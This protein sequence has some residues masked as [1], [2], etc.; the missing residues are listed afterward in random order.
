MMICMEDC[1]SGEKTGIFRFYKGENQEKT[2][3]FHEIQNNI[4]NWHARCSI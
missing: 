3:F 4:K 1:V 2:D